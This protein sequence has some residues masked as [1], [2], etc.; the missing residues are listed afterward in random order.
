MGGGGVCLH[1][2]SRFAT[3]TRLYRKNMNENGI[4]IGPVA[5]VIETIFR[6][7]RLPNE[8]G[9]ENLN[10][11]KK[12]IRNHVY[13]KMLHLETRDVLFCNIFHYSK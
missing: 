11:E 4:K 13:T 8:F 7:V 3:A 2:P 1:A 5:S 9:F 6:L 10:Y 12:S